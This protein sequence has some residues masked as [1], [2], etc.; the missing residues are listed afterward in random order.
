MALL[1]SGPSALPPAVLFELE[2]TDMVKVLVKADA[3]DD[4]PKCLSSIW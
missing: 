3:E 1:T 4:D 2:D